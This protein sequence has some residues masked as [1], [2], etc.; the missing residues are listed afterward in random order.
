MPPK[1]RI[2]IV[3]DEPVLAENLRDYLLKR[4]ADVKIAGC[5]EDALTCAEAFQPDLMVLDYHLPGMNGLQTCDEFRRRGCTAE[6]I[7]VTAYAMDDVTEL[8]SR[9]GIT[10]VLIKPF[11]FADLER[12]LVLKFSA[13]ATRRGNG[14]RRQAM[15]EGEDRGGD[16]GISFPLRTR[17]GEIVEADR[18]R[19]ERRAEGDRRDTA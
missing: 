9:H 12:I 17:H 6:C 18:R 2:L 15:R 8:A 3:E 19:G 4:G 7:L 1:T 16:D 10:E 13:P 11:S 14:E 5:G